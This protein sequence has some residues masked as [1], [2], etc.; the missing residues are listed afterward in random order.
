MDRAKEHLLQWYGRYGRHSLPWRQE[1]SPYR[2]YISEVML[3]QTQVERVASIYYP[4]FLKRFATLKEL[5]K[6]SQEE[7][8]ALWSGLGYYRRAINLHKSAKISR[9]CLPKSYEALLEL[10]GIGRYTASAICSFAYLQ[11]IAV[12]DTNIQRVLRRLFALEDPKQSAMWQAAQTFLNQKEPRS[13]NLALMDLGATLCT[14][15][16]PHCD[17]CPLSEACRGKGEIARFSTKSTKHY[18]SLTLHFGLYIKEGRVATVRSS[19]G[20]YKGML[21][22]PTIKPD[23][24]EPLGEYRHS[25]TKYRVRVYLYKIDSYDE[26]LEWV[27]IDTFMDAAL[28]SLIKKCYPFIKECI[29]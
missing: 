9:G 29:Q 23:F 22:L 11:P 1:S 14:P 4:R 25:F 18:E 16:L 26:P 27:E 6:A 20:M 21:L 17:I 8:L 13:H 7:V 10:P 15:H 28:P 19:E 24:K 5:A 12:V 2:V 3:Q